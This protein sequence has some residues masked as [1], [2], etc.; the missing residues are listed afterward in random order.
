MNSRFDPSN[1][2]RTKIDG[3]QLYDY[4]TDKKNI[5]ELLLSKKK[6]CDV[7]IGQQGQPDEYEIH[8]C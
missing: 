1:K 8:Q 3:D 6:N 5:S 7:K 4:Y 2:C